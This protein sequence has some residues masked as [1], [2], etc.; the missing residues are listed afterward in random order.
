MLT[1]E[2][3][4]DE[5]LNRVIERQ[6]FDA[7]KSKYPHSMRKGIIGDWRNYFTSPEAELM[8]SLYG[9]EIRL[10]GYESDDSWVQT[11]A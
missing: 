3:V 9:K 11:V 1:G 5:K 7:W 6:R 10:L 8:E 4:S 2:E